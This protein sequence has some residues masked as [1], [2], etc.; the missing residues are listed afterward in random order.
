MDHSVKVMHTHRKIAFSRLWIFQQRR[1]EN[2]E[3]EQL[4]QRYIFKLQ[5]TSIVSALLLLSLLSI[6]IA[7]LQFY[8]IQHT[9]TLIG[10][11]SLIQSVIFL[12]LFLSS[13]RMH[14]TQLLALCYVIIFFCILFCLLLSP[15][16]NNLHYLWK[17]LIKWSS[18]SSSSIDNDTATLISQQKPSDGLWAIVF[19]I[20]LTYT[21]LPIKILISFMFGLCISITHLSITIIN[22]SIISITTTTNTSSII[23][24][25]ENFIHKQVSN[26]CLVLYYLINFP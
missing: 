6:S 10:I 17:L 21:M 11:Y 25:H 18:S 7:L 9:V 26:F 4:Y 1:F 13:F 2:Q 24:V 20:F 12:L 16:D 22:L 8:Y 19:V 5:Q 14:D 3:L 15:I 23:A